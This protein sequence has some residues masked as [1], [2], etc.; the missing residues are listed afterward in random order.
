[1]PPSAWNTEPV[2][3]TRYLPPPMALIEMVRGPVCRTRASMSIFLPF[4]FEISSRIFLA[5]PDALSSAERCSS[6]PC[7]FLILASMAAVF[8]L[9]SSLTSTVGATSSGMPCSP[10]TKRCVSVIALRIP[11][12]KFSKALLPVSLPMP[13]MASA[14]GVSRLV[15]PVT[16]SLIPGNRTLFHTHLKMLP[17][18]VNM[19]SFLC[20][21][22]AMP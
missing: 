4:S 15:S 19:P 11:A 8:L 13:S 3:P 16:A 21:H 18:E 14:S 20:T 7:S 22:S 5:L 2:E 12:P 9:A 1:M 6:L 17:S 10:S